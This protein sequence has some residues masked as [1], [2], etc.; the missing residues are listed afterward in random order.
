MTKTIAVLVPTG[1]HKDKR[2]PLPSRVT[3]LNGKVIGFLWNRKP[4]ADILLRR[5]QEQL[6]QR[7]RL[8][9]TSWVLGGMAATVDPAIIEELTR[10]SDTV[11]IAS[12]D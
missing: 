1:E 2:I 3:D 4:N 7:F 5:I 10:T 9:G 6:S 11:I 8:A 12:G